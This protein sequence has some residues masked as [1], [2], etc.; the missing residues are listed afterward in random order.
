MANCLYVTTNNSSIQDSYFQHFF[1]ATASTVSWKSQYC[2]LE[3]WKLDLDFLLDLHAV[4]LVIADLTLGA[5]VA[6]GASVPLRC[7]VANAVSENNVQCTSFK[8][9]QSADMLL[10][11][12]IFILGGFVPSIIKEKNEFYYNSKSKEFNLI[13]LLNHLIC[14]LF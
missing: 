8:S 3:T 9:V 7:V 11:S 4:L 1:F 5:S 6:L 14:L 12:K 13:Y 2:K 10:F